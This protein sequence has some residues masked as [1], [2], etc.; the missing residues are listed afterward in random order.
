RPTRARVGAARG[1]RALPRR[2]RRVDRDARA[3]RALVDRPPRGVGAVTETYVLREI[4]VL[5][6]G[7]GF[8]APEDVLV[9]NGRIAAVRP[10]LAAPGA[11]AETDCAG[12]G[13]P[14]GIVDCR[15]HVAV[16]SL[17]PLERLRPPVTQWALEAAQNAR[18]VLEC[19]V[20]LLRDPGGADAGIRDAIAAGYVPGPRLQVAVVTLCQTGGHAPRYLPGANVECSADYVASFPGRPPYLVDGADDM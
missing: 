20:T 6:D 16:S 7:G 17:A 1:D 4:A 3:D 12:L 15:S 8:G 10:G 9:E 13:L 14:P 19:G 2:R 5:D 11:G 18:R